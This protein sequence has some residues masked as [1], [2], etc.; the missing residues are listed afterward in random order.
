MEMHPLRES[1][2][3]PGFERDKEEGRVKRGSTALN[4][5]VFKGEK[6]GFLVTVK[7]PEIS[8]FTRENEFIFFLVKVKLI[9][10]Y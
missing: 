8:W 4:P 10:K 1:K 5:S 6:K 3:S 2:K 7:E 9:M